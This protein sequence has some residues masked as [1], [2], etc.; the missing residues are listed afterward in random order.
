MQH[1]LVELQNRPDGITNSSIK[2]YSS[3]A[4]GLAQYYARASVAVTTKDYTSVV[5]T[6][7][8][9]E[10]DIVQNQRFETQYEAPTGE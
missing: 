8:S 5:L 4:N 9:A 1:F 2:S 3:L 7:T 6:L 10:G